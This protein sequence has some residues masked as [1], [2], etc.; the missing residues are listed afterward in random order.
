MIHA[1]RLF[2]TNIVLDV[3]SG[4]VHVF[5]DTAFNVVLVYND[6]KKSGFQFKDDNT[7]AEKVTDAL[8]AGILP[9]RK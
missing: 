4:A 1:Y 6:L 2:D 8:S 7:L 3:N 9:H 5:D